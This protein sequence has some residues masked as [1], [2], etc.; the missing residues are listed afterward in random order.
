MLKAVDVWVQEKSGPIVWHMEKK[1]FSCCMQK[2]VEGGCG[3][4]MEITV[5]GVGACTKRE[6]VVSVH[7]DLKSVGGC[8]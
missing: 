2:R 1:V 4:C 7:V 8:L 3:R 5:I 6:V